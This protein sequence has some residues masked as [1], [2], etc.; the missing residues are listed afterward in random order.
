M[1]YL[2]FLAISCIAAGSLT[3]GSCN[4]GAEEKTEEAKKDSGAA[5]SETTV[6]PS[7]PTSVM[8]VRHKVADYAK[9]KPGY[10]AHD[11][12][13]VANGLHG[14]VVARGTEDSNTV[15]IAMR[16]DDVTKAKAFGSS[17]ELQDRMKSLG[18]VGPPM[19]DYLELVLNDTA[20][21]QATT[22]VIIRHKVKDWDAWKKS[23]DSHKQTRIDAGMSDRA[24]GYS[25]GDNHSVSV[26]FAI[27]DQ[28]KADAFM[29]SQDLKDKMKE[30]G[31]EGPPDIFYYKVV[32]K[33]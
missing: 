14:Y 33:N 25:V 5:K 9:W 15:L 7:G 32:Q 3:L 19:V 11:S 28:A 2:K 27:T 23:F 21:I 13:R 17:K 22:R 10:D 30:A 29:K 24:I 6:A 18:V 8:L 31:V 4:S 16:M 20:A 12:A 1:K 26:V